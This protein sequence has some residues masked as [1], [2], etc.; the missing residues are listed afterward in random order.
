MWLKFSSVLEKLCDRGMKST[1]L[2]LRDGAAGREDEA[3]GIEI[4]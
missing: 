1:A 4:G 2:G 3:E